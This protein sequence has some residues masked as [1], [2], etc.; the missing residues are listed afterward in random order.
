M[1]DKIFA[2]VDANNFYVSCERVFQPNLNTVPLVVLSNNDGCVVARSQEVKD[3]GVKMAV[4][5]FKIR[6]LA[7]QHHIIALSSNYTLYADMSARMMR[8]LSDFSQH[9]EVY[10]IDECFLDLTDF[11]NYDL[12]QYSH[13]IRNR[14]K[15][16]LGLPTCV[17]I[18]HTKTLSKLANYIAKKNGSYNGVCNLNDFSDIDH[19]SMLQRI[20]INEIWGVGRRL[21]LRL[22]EIHIQTCWDLQQASPKR[23]RELFGV[24]M[25]RIVAELNGESCIELEEVTPNKKQIICSRSF[26]NYIS[27]QD[28]LRQAMA[29]YVSRAS[30]KLRMQGSLTNSL[31]AFVEINRFDSKT[32]QYH[33]AHTIKLGKPSSDTRILTEVAWEALSKLY[34]PGLLYKKCGVILSEFTQKTAYQ[35][36]LFDMPEDIN[37]SENLMALMDQINHTMGKGSIK[38][39]SEG[40]KDNWKMAR[41]N[42]SGQFTS[43]INEIVKVKAK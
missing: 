14:I 9:V 30:E 27:S 16:Y 6:D 29:S 32:A 36:S 26:G 12:N 4:P 3:L 20:P 13:I 42:V 41:K 35:H 33:S 17:G 11:S 28:E 40:T 7:K 18:G 1:K 22:N 5:W 15:D 8:I 38:L 21:A 39:L 43:S 24:V 10:S 25:E 31:Y 23:L 34:R 19:Q 37:K 2:L